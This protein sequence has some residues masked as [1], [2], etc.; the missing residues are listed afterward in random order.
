MVTLHLYK[1]QDG[2]L[3][4]TPECSYKAP[5]NAELMLVSSG[6]SEAEVQ[7]EIDRFIGLPPYLEVQ[8]LF[9][10]ALDSGLAPSEA[11]KQVENE[12]GVVGAVVW[13]DHFAHVLGIERRE[14][15]PLFVVWW[16]DSSTSEMSDDEFNTRIGVLKN[17]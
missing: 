13:P 7:D 6:G 17:A 3:T 4:T 8:R 10:A 15:Q 14:V 16:P 5:A 1:T 2:W 12:V 9:K 11:V